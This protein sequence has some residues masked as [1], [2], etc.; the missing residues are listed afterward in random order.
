MLLKKIQYYEIKS[1]II[2]NWE[3]LIDPYESTYIDIGIIRFFILAIDP[4]VVYYQSY[5]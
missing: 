1:T 4:I 3:D 2:N 5:P